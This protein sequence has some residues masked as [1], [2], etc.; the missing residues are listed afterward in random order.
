VA[1]FSAILGIIGA[2]IAAI[3]CTALWRNEVARRVREIGIRIA[4]GARA[5]QI[6]RTTIGEAAVVRNFQLTLTNV[7]A[8]ESP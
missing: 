3:G 7:S 2:V 6:V 5:W 1:Q 4:L 8:T